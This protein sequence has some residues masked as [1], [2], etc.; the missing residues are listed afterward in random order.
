MALKTN[1][2]FAPPKI[3]DVDI[4]RNVKRV[5]KIEF[6]DRCYLWDFWRG[7]KIKTPNIID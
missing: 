6:I 4:Q 7:G 3:N 2:Y 5:E 1:Q